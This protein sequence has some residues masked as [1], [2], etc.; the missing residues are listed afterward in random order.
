MESKEDSGIIPRAM[1]DLLA[2][3]TALEGGENKVT[4]TVSFFELLDTVRDLLVT[5]RAGEKVSAR[6]TSLLDPN[7]DLTGFL[8]G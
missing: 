6:L 1:R 4:V 3:S 8:P 7:P 5:S 2:F